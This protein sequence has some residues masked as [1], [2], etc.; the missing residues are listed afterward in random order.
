MSKHPIVVVV[1]SGVS[2]IAQTAI[3]ERG[4]VIIQQE[5]VHEV[6]EV[7]NYHKPLPIITTRM[8]EDSEKQNYIT[9]KKLPRKKKR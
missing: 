4:I 3:Q 6:F 8:V 1:G 9:G 5:P 7:K 2:K